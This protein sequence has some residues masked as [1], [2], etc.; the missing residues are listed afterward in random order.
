[1]NNRTSVPPN[2]SQT[3]A[4]D[5][6]PKTPGPARRRGAP[7]GNRNA[8]KHGL[9]SKNNTVANLN[10]LRENTDLGRADRVVFLAAWEVNA[11]KLRDPGNKRL[12][13]LAVGRFFDAVGKRYGITDPTDIDA[14]NTAMDKVAAEL[15]LPKDVMDS[16][17]K[18][19]V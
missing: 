6:G 17:S 15:A 14:L 4:R 12:H 2:D 1:M 7:A 18:Q 3:A 11:V 10:V 13:R 16:L 5:P 8:C 19:L 9:Y